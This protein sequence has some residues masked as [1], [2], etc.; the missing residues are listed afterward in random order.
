MSERKR[1]VLNDTAIRRGAVKRQ[2]V[3]GFDPFPSERWSLDSGEFSD[4]PNIV[5]C[6]L[7]HS[8]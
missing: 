7:T 2:S 3:I 4:I 5:N 1:D 8:E 6:H